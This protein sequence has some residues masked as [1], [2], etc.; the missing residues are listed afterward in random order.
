[1]SHIQRK[2][3]GQCE[4]WFPDDPGHS[5]PLAGGGC[6]YASMAFET[7]GGAVRCRQGLAVE[8]VVAEHM[9]AMPTCPYDG[10]ITPLPALCASNTL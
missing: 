9:M 2:R 7:R 10:S 5:R 3:V 1:M 8:L 4:T 6:A